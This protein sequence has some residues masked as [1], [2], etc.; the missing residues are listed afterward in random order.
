[1]TVTDV[2]NIVKGNEALRLE[3][4]LDSRGNPTKGWGH[5]CEPGTPVGTK[6]TRAQ[7]EDLFAS[8]MLD[9]LNAAVGALS[10]SGSP[11]YA[12][13]LQD[14]WNRDDLQ[15]RQTAMIDLAFNLGEEGMLKF[16]G[17]L[18]AVN[19]GD[20]KRAA[21]E[22]MLTDPVRTNRLDLLLYP[23]NVM[24]PYAKQVGW[25]AKYNAFRLALNAEPP[26][27]M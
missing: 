1:M 18:R 5:L 6:I 4:Y 2:G 19:T 11:A 20:W 13:V 15:P 7:A 24:T 22:L 21:E 23:E 8:D 12:G 17:M 3:V 14:A 25:R 9:A 27:H 26:D 10:R 16:P